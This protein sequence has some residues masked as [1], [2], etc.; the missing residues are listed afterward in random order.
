MDPETPLPSHLPTMPLPTNT[1][2]HHRDVLPSQ[3]GP[4]AIQGQHQLTLGPPSHL[5][6][7]HTMLWPKLSTSRKV[8]RIISKIPT[9]AHHLPEIFL[10][11]SWLPASEKRPILPPGGL[12]HI[13]VR[14]LRTLPG[15]WG[16]LLGKGVSR[17]VTWSLTDKQ[18][19]MEIPSPTPRQRAFQQQPPPVV[20]LSQPMSQ[21]TGL[22][23]LVHTGSVNTSIPR[24]GVKTDQEEL[25]AQVGGGGS[26]G[27]AL[28]GEESAKDR[29]SVPGRRA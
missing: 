25:L 6:M 22:K 5:L 7:S 10:C 16:S 3:E 26:S 27:T 1:L 11:V 2:D 12:P 28:S 21:I 19:E 13:Q 24:F 20:R 14:R 4:L 15:M 18:N 9:P 17:A 29:P 8:L 23:K